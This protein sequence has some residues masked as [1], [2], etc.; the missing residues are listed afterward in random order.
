MENQSNKIAAVYIVRNEEIYIENSIKSV[1]PYVSQIV[2]V[3]TGSTDNTPS[4]ASKLGAEV[5]F[6]KWDDD[7]SKARNFALEHVRRDWIIALDADEII[8]DKLSISSSTL[9]DQN[10]GGITCNLISYLNQNDF[11]QYSQHKYTRIFRHRKDIFYTGI[12]HEQ[13]RP[14]LEDLNLEIIDSQV[15]IYHFGYIDPDNE[16]KIRNKNLLESNLDLN[17]HYD[18]FHLAETEFSLSNNQKAKELFLSIYDSDQLDLPSKE[19]TR[20]KLAQI[21]LAEDEHDQLKTFLQFTSTDTHVEGF[22]KFILAA[23]ALINKDF[24]Q[25]EQLYTS[26]EVENSA[27]VDK[28]TVEKALKVINAST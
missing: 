10:I 3:D 28:N 20:I 17:Q 15:E 7:F 25:A 8:T 1:S 24:T 12:I 18:V 26:E 21:A 27:L 4:I 22:R 2:V 5:Y 23:N 9:D 14:S 13:I 6:Y 16:K 19:K 11:S